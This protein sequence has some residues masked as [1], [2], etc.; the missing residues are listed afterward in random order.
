M[1]NCGP[2]GMGQAPRNVRR[3]NARFPFRSFFFLIRNL[4]RNL[5]LIVLKIYSE[6]LIGLAWDDSFILFRL[7]LYIFWSIVDIA[8]NKYV[9]YRE[10]W[11][12]ITSFGVFTAL[13]I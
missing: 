6:Q 1:G 13:I 9:D 12:R 5:I 8:L 7:L 3:F 11:I 2:T 10:M 4:E